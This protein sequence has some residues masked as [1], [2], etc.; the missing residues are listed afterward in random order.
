VKRQVRLLLALAVVA[1]AA[2]WM[3]LHRGNAA[4]EAQLALG[5][6]TQEVAP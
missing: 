5:A 3:G 1:L 2:G 4:L 6:T